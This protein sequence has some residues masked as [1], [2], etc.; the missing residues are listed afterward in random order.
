MVDISFITINYNSSQ[1][2]ISLVE[3]IIKNS[4]DILYEIIIVDNASKK[5]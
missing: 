1:Y 2:T 5:R 4:S 3:S